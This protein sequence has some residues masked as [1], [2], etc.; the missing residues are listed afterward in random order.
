MN[1]GM[2][3][4]EIRLDDGRVFRGRIGNVSIDC[5]HDQLSYNYAGIVKVFPIGP[6][7]TT[8]TAEIIDPQI[9]QESELEQRDKTALPKAEPLIK[10]KRA[11]TFED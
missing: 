6:S 4:I 10:F 9:S 5:R 8:I 2:G 11:I 1:F 3:E 7:T